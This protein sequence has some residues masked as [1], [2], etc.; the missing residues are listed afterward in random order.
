M[1]RLALPAV[2]AALLLTGCGTSDDSRQARATT[3]RFY[4]AFRHHDG[5]L[6]CHQLTAAAAQQ[7]AS[8]EG[9]PCPQAVTG[10]SLKGGAVVGVQVYITNAKVDLAQH[11]SAFLSRGPSGWKIGSVGCAH[12]DKPADHPYTCELES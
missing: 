8:Q 5:A 11:V 9:K 6:A 7:L 10:L 3:E 1:R 2:A 4:A 12:D